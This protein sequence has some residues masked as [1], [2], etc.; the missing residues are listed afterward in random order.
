M[1]RT[2][3]MPLTAAVLAS[4]ITGPLWGQPTREAF[5]V[6]KD[7]VAVSRDSVGWSVGI[8]NGDV[9]SGGNGG[10]FSNTGSGI[11]LRFRLDTPTNPTRFGPDYLTEAYDFGR[12]LSIGDGIVAVAVDEVTLPGTYTG[13]G[14]HDAETTILQRYLPGYDSRSSGFFSGPVVVGSG[15]VA[16]QARGEV[17][18]YSVDTGELVH[19]LRASSGPSGHGEF[20]SS[21]A[22]EGT[23]LAAG[24]PRQF[25]SD[26]GLQ[27]DGIQSVVLFELSSGLRIGSIVSPDPQVGDAN[28]NYFAISLALSNGLLAVGAPARFDDLT[29]RV[30]IYNAATLELMHTLVS[31][32]PVLGDNFGQRLAA[33]NGLLVVNGGAVFTDPDCVPCGFTNTYVYD[34]LT[35]ELL[36]MFI[37]PEEIRDDR[38]GLGWFGFS[39][40]IEDNLV[41]IG[42]PRATN[43]PYRPDPAGAV[44]LYEIV[45]TTVDC[46][47]DA[48]G[49]G[50]L[51][52]A[53]FSAWITAFNTQSPA[54][55]QNEDGLC[56][57]FDFTAWIINF[58]AGCD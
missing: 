36:T 11:G 41:A 27:P 37:A 42:A 53:D 21:L 10:T 28:V 57:P 9:F 12:W 17:R 25:L 52:P 30:Y 48:N 8:A 43:I 55:D 58:N 3:P 31:P 24:N 32:N 14:L 16:A 35:G 46:L 56:T 18:V 7:P 19:E 15:M 26:P 5:M 54:C 44:V 40:A 23:L 4:A 6:L 22:I 20:G 47:P 38:G 13:F 45:P 50:L 49:D 2:A 1:I 39:V 29:G 33:D 34:M 51:S